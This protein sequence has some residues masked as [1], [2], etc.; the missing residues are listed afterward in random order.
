LLPRWAQI[1]LCF[2]KLFYKK[3]NIFL[4]N[5][6]RQ[7]LSLSDQIPFFVTGITSVLS[8]LSHIL[9]PVELHYLLDIKDRMD[10]M[11]KALNAM[12]GFFNQIFECLFQRPSSTNQDELSKFK[13]LQNYCWLL[14][15]YAKSIF[16]LFY[17]KFF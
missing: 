8:F 15:C 11:Y 6:Y 2:L 9:S 17:F 1:Y 12:Y 5:K 16:Y 14:C 7:D 3:T 10:I 13:D 4:T